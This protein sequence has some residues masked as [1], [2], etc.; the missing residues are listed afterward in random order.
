MD[1]FIQATKKMETFRSEDVANTASY[2]IQA[3]D[4][5]NVNKVLTRPAAQDN[6]SFYHFS[7][8][9]FISWVRA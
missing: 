6:N 3:P 4:H 8:P 5:A 9:F 1:G 2:L 7:S